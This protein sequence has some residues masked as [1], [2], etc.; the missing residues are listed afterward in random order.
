[1][2]ALAFPMKSFFRTFISSEVD[3]EMNLIELNVAIGI[4]ITSQR[5]GHHVNNIKLRNHI[6]T[7]ST[8]V[9]SLRFPLSFIEEYF[10]DSIYG[11]ACSY[12]LQ[13]INIFYQH[14]I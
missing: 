11:L 8:A 10:Y 9:G 5:R 7:I 12:P 1:M 3:V 4:L 14:E 6:K 2:L 13:S